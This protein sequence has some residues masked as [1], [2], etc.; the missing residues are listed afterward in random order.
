MSSTYRKKKKNYSEKQINQ[1][2]QDIYGVHIICIA[3]RNRF[4]L[5]CIWFLPSYPQSWPVS[6]LL[7]MKNCRNG[8]FMLLMFCVSTECANSQKL[9]QNSV[10]TFSSEQ[11]ILYRV[12]TELP[13]PNSSR[14]SSQHASINIVQHRG[15]SKLWSPCRRL[16]SID[17]WMSSGP[18]ALPLGFWLLIC[19]E[20]PPYPGTDLGWML[21]SKDLCHIF[22]VVFS[23][24]MLCGR[25]GYLFIYFFGE[26]YH[27]RYL[28]R[29]WFDSSLV[30]MMLFV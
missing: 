23:H 9:A 21:S 1:K 26:P 4:W 12:S 13:P 15:E 8:V 27:D 28:S 3:D 24:G 22:D 6:R 25:L 11:R 2:K 5:T 20:W 18:S 16:L 29:P 19:D 17:L 10:F 7:L 30:L 14:L